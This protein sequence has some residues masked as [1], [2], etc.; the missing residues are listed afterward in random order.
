[1]PSRKSH[2]GYHFAILHRCMAAL[3]KQDIMDMGIQASQIPFVADLLHR[4]APVTQDE[5]SAA[6]FIDKAAT[7]R[8]LDQLEKNGFV[9]RTV[10]PENRRQKLVA[11]T[12]RARAIQE[13][14]YGV[15]Q[16]ASDRLTHNFSRK[17][18]EQIRKLLD[19]MIDSAMGMNK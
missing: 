19:Q 14:F 12:A 11:A 15:L 1:M 16:T 3:C 8:A 4:D 13:K 9:S 5:L 10:N 17:E 7:A 18:M 2:F 6:L